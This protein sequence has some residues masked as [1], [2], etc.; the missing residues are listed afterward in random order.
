MRYQAPCPTCGQPISVWRIIVA[1]TPLNYKCAKCGEKFYAKDWTLISI[2]GGL[3]LV[4]FLGW[5][6]NYGME[7][8]RVSPPLAFAV[9]VG[10]FA[11]AEIVHSFLVINK[12]QLAAKRKQK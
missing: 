4:G 10:V 8:K 3:L 12:A 2:A 1:A 7:T 6:L 11:A 5:I 9:F